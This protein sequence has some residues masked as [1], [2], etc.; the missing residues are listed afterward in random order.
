KAADG[1][2]L[3]G[4]TIVLTEQTTRFEFAGIGQTPVLSIN[5]GFSAPINLQ[6]DL[7]TDDLAFLAA[8]DSDAFNRWQALQTISMRLLL[9]NV[10]ATR[11]GQPLRKDDKLVQAFATTLEDSSL[12]P[13]FVALALI[14]PSEG[15]VAREIGKDIDPDAIFQARTALRVE[16]GQ[17]LGASLASV[18]ERMADAGR[19]S[20]DAKSA[21]RRALRNA[22][23]DLLA[24]NGTPTAIA[25]ADRQYRNA[26]NMT[27]RMAALATLSLHHVAERENALAD[28]YSR[29]AGDAL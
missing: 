25:R 18:H 6:T 15:D 13:A 14:L 24:A 26:D 21:G 27:D 7:D 10:A 5:R 4:E 9:A 2:S 16:L 17:R 8:R 12:E 19:Y 20:P 29:Y 22:A 28:F 11:T 1:R 23:L 3:E